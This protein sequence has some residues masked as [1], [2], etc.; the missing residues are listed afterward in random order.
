M[1]LFWLRVSVAVVLAQGVNT[2]I[3]NHLWVRVLLELAALCIGAGLL[4][5][6]FALLV[7]LVEIFLTVAPS[8]VEWRAPW[9][10]ASILVALLLLGPGA[11]SMD[12]W[13]FGRKRLTIRRLPS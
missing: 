9:L 8:T 10:A 7:A 6:V 13:L 4:T 1:A 2:W 11:Y 3:G 12:R 5:P